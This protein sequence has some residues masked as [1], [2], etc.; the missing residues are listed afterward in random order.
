MGFLYKCVGEKKSLLSGVAC[1]I[2]PTGIGRKKGEGMA[3]NNGKYLDQR[4]K[5][6][7]EHGRA[8]LS[9]EVIPSSIAQIRG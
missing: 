8:G 4:F 3:Y 2:G 5:R 6:G 7:S 1:W 9:Q